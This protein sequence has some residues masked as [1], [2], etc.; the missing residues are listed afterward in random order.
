MRFGSQCYR[1]WNSI[2]LTDIVPGELISGAYDAGIERNEVRWIRLQD[3]VIHGPCSLQVLKEDDTVFIVPR[4]DELQRQ[5]GEF[6]PAVRAYRPNIVHT[7]LLIFAWEVRWTSTHHVCNT[8][9]K[10]RTFVEHGRHVC[11]PF[12]KRLTWMIANEKKSFY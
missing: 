11:V 10:F 3:A 4:S 5:C 12:Q 8:C 9:V 1:Q 2:P 6:Q 7:L